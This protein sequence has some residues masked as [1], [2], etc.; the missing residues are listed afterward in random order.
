MDTSQ[1]FSQMTQDTGKSIDHVMNEFKTLH[2][3]KANSSMVENVSVDVY[4]SAMKL[5]DIAAI[6]T[7]DARTIQIQPW[8]KSSC[9]PIEKALLEAK[10]GITPL[11]TGEII[12]LPIPELSGERREELCKIAQ[13]FAEQSRVGVRASRKEAMDALK[14]AQ[15]DGL[16]EDDFKRAE[17]NV[18]KNTDDAVA[19]INDALAQ[20]EADLRQV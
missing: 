1:I 20:K 2:T 14:I 8:D 10:I 17:K 15:K 12:R 18:Q 13:G 6:T 11:I 9:A 4:G 3:G 16:P 5:R 7:P 19:K